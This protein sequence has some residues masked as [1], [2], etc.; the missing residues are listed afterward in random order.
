MLWHRIRVRKVAAGA[1][2]V[3]AERV[4]PTH[5]SPAIRRAQLDT[6]F[7]PRVVAT[8]VYDD[9]G[10]VA[11]L[12][13][14]SVN[15]A[16]ALFLGLAADDLRGRRFGDVNPQ[17]TD[18][19]IWRRLA[20][21]A[22]T[23][24]P[25]DLSEFRHVDR[26]RGEVL[27]INVRAGRVGRLLSISWQDV[28]ER[29]RIVERFRL[30]AENASDAVFQ[31]DL[32]TRI[33][34]ASPS[35]HLVLGWS[36]D[37]LVG[38]D[39]VDLLHP[40]DAANLERWADELD[41]HQATS[42]EA[43]LRRAS[44][45][46]SSF[47]ITIRVVLTDVGV[48]ELIGSLRNIDREVAQRESMRLLGT[49]Y[50]LIAENALDVV[51]VGT[52]DGRMLWIFDTVYQLLG[53]RP[54]ELIGRHFDEFIHPDDLPEARSQRA[55]MGRGERITTEVR[56][57]QP[58]GSYHWL[59]ITGRDLVDD[60]G[61]TTTRIVSW[62]DAEIEVAQR[63]AM[64]DSESQYRLLAENASDV[65]WRTD[66]NGVIG[67]VSPSVHEM[68]GWRPEEL[69]GRSVH[70][71]H[72]GDDVAGP[73][74]A[75]ARAR[76]GERIEPYEC[77]YRTA[78]G[79]SRWMRTHLRALVD[80]TGRATAIV[81]SLHDVQALVQGRR[82]FNALATGNAIL[83]RAVN[84]QDLLNQL[85][86][87]L[88]DEGGYLLA[89]YGRP[90][91]DEDQS[92][93]AVASSKDHRDYTTTIHVSWGDNP[94]GNGPTGRAVRTGVAVVV[95]DLHLTPAFAPWREL[96]ARH[97][98]RSLMALPVR[99]DG[100]LDGVFTVYAADADAFDP[101]TTSTLKDL[102]LQVGI[103]LHRLREEE[104]LAHAL[105]ESNLLNTAIDQAVESIIIADE[106]A[107]ILFA[108]P[109]ASLT[110]G[111]ST[112][113]LIGANPNVFSSGLH[114]RAFY[115]T[116][117][118]TLDRG[119]PWHGIITNRRKNG[120][121]Y[122][123]DTTISPVFGDDSEVRGYVAVKRDL[124]VQR[125]LEANVERG[126]RDAQDVV[127]L[128]REVRPLETFEE[129]AA[130]FCDALLRI[131][132]ID[133][134]LIT[135]RQVDGTLIS[136][137]AAGVT[138]EALQPGSAFTVLD[139]D[140]FFARSTAGAWWIDLLNPGGFGEEPLVELARQSGFTSVVVAP[141]RWNGEVIGALVAG[142]LGRVDADVVQA[143]LAVYEELGA[144]AGGLVGA[145]ADATGRREATRS[146]VRG[147]IDRER[148][149][150]VFQPIVDLATSTT[151][152][153]E[154]L[155]RFDDGQAPDLHF[156]TATAVG[157]GA[158]LEMACA[159]RAVADAVVLPSETW[160]SL[161]FSPAVVIT[162]DLANI[163]ST[164]PRGVAI[165]ITEHARVE[166]YEEVRRM[167]ASVDRCRLFVDDAGA[168]YAGLHHILELRP[169]VVKLDISLVRDIDHDPAR[170]ALVSGMRHF[171]DLTGTL[172]LG[173]GVE[174]AAEAD[175]LRSLGVDLG[176][177][178]YFGR[179]AIASHF[180]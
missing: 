94:N 32:D 6:E 144:F 135:L 29:A 180:A 19:P 138:L 73:A 93:V 84:D 53:W 109:A 134:T 120:D 95:N 105:H 115:A 99:V 59:A 3:M 79:G 68:L 98:F 52:P 169:D 64:A 118:S 165:E 152:G 40:D 27:V 18:D 45:D 41:H 60:A 116:L 147:V 97:D 80:E 66:V 146:T 148:F 50:Q 5:D 46:Y 70:E 111:Y 69:V 179:P 130:S 56:V 175:V 159:A 125:R 119:E 82:A 37:E 43:R 20:H 102:A 140:M 106:S 141:I 145:Q 153:F 133:A 35:S 77:R 107:R 143:R 57:R 178:Y 139:R 13:F 10:G 61:A 167:I 39:A 63:Q 122:E 157:M 132:F 176:Q 112:D 162:P 26:R 67:W 30:L 129:T 14:T 16:A 42:F 164:I 110:S 151:V 62:R 65:I 174:T 172:L 34:W 48:S 103:G 75:L 160:I 92:I 156:A 96:A 9:D 90:T 163:I 33:R 108:N 21:V 85:C 87:N 150:A 121:L 131:D 166:D 113:E 78:T 71:F 36:P 44:G 12:E 74:D 54:D 155:T 17:A 104:R 158:E 124:S 4:A 86:Q 15:A 11:D 76:R 72:A 149:H 25:L 173:E 89:W 38:V 114:D 23:G 8:I 142:S 7:D 58:D 127:S 100:V 49:R 171:A 128:M 170:Q 91:H 55:A 28:T 51:V 168:G 88:V 177:G 101:A 123:E 161:N 31:T 136:A 83:V 154:A 47:A 126:E 1:G 117:W 22:E 2:T 24:E 137:A 81:F